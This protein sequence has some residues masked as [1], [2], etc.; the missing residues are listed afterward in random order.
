MP[1][2]KVYAIVEGHGEADPPRPGRE[3]AAKIL[4]AKLLV[5]LETIHPGHTYPGD[6]E[7]PRDF[8]TLCDRFN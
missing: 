5:S 1:R 4:I 7:T 2:D 3:P 6:P 8:V